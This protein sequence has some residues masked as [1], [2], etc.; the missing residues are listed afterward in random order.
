MLTPK[1]RFEIRLDKPMR[2]IW[3]L[4]FCVAALA[5]G[6]GTANASA[7]AEAE[8]AMKFPAAPV[9]NSNC[10]APK[11]ISCEEQKRNNPACA[12]K[13]PPFAR[14]NNVQGDIEVEFT[15]DEQGDYNNMRVISRKLSKTSV[16]DKG[17]NVTDVTHIFDL[18][19]MQA[20]SG[21]RCSSGCPN[22][23][24]PVIVRTPFSFK[25]TD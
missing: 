20:A 21:C 11:K 10:A 17:G 14:K 5:G 18:A 7:Y 4:F 8:R 6:I 23:T 19:A 16:T 24:K 12:I 1:V 25:L 13:Y 22:P 9:S 15:V 3:P 2:K